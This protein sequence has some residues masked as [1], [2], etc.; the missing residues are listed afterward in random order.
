MYT[1]VCD[2]SLSLN[3][4]KED[5]GKGSEINQKKSYFLN[6]RRYKSTHLSVANSMGKRI[7]QRKKAKFLKV[8]IQ[9]FHVEDLPTRACIF[10]QKR[11]KE[12]LYPG[13][14]GRNFPKLRSKFPKRVQIHLASS[15]F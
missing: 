11:S 8:E 5:P 2:S 15:A 7:S 10:H 6:I 9:I 1:S 14:R 13:K 12:D 3:S 4:T